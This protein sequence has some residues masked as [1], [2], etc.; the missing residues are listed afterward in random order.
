LPAIEKVL[1]SDVSN[2]DFSFQGFLEAL[3]KRLL[4]GNVVLGCRMA[5]K[6]GA[7]HAV[8]LSVLTFCLAIIG[9]FHEVYRAVCPT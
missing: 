9:A 5:L 6:D 8:D 4:S 3:E 1:V 2:P 7:F